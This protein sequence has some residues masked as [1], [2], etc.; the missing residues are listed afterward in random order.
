MDKIRDWGRAV[1]REH[2]EK[3]YS[4]IPIGVALTMALQIGAIIWY[5]SNQSSRLS[6]MEAL[7]TKH[8][9]AGG[10]GGMERRMATVEATVPYIKE[11]LDGIEGKINDAILRD[12]RGR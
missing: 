9:D 8:F 1:T 4:A 11:R 5:A 12:T 3:M 10:H 7:S 6:A 2:V